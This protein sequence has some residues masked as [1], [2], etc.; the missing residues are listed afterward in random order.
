M[1]DETR[2]GPVKL[3]SGNTSQNWKKFEQRFEIFLK[4]D[5]KRAEP[6]ANK[7]AMLMQ[8][9]GREALEVYNSFRVK[10]TTVTLTPE[11]VVQ[12]D[13]KSEDYEAV[14]KEFRAYAE[15]KKSVSSIRKQFNHRNQK[16]GEP[17]GTWFT[18]I[19]NLVKDC[20]YENVTD[21]MLK[22]RLEWGSIDQKVRETI[23]ENPQWTLDQ[24]ILCCKAAEEKK[25]EAEE[26]GR[27]VD[28]LD[29]KKAVKRN[30]SEMSR[31]GT[32]GMNRGRGAPRSHY[33]SVRGRGTRGHHAPPRG[34]YWSSH[35]V[36][37]AYNCKKC[38]TR[39]RARRCPAFDKTCNKCG[40]VGHYEKV[41]RFNKKR[42]IETVTKVA[43]VLKPEAIKPKEPEKKEENLYVL[44]DFNFEDEVDLDLLHEDMEVAVL[45]TKEDP[46]VKKIRE[47]TEILKLKGK[48]C[49]NF[50]L[51]PGADV[52][53]IPYN[54]FTCI[55]AEGDYELHPSTLSFQSNN[56]KL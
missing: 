48:H 45:Q 3:T 35:Y 12:K 32:R 11:G 44:D 49:V 51:D 15:V 7:W 23:R 22:D 20:E 1:G 18:E 34:G 56:F 13:D 42:K 47:Y 9:A 31:G 28:S 10:L 19:K 46:S 25:L 50:K 14:I 37:E 38:Q 26:E 29:T 55:N 41:C 27:S 4:A 2:P 36:E 8:E 24:A 21:S 40:E 52:N 16:P 43:E 30:Y 5:P 6:P 54:V 53:I 33:L 39:H 17:F